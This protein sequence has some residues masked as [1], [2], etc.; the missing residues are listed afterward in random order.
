M[1]Y[2]YPYSKEF[3]SSDLTKLSESGKNN[4]YKQIYKGE[5]DRENVLKQKD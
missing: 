5:Q 4:W 1:K 3:G 2:T